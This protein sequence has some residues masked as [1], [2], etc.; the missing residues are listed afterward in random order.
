MRRRVWIGDAW[1]LLSS[2]HTA[3]SIRLLFIGDMDPETKASHMTLALIPF[4]PELMDRGGRSVRLMPRKGAGKHFRELRM[5]C[6]GAADH[7]KLSTLESESPAA[8][9][10]TLGS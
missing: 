7:R 5:Q 8:Q 9:R 2:D 1:V 6:K 10:K 3:A 4:Y